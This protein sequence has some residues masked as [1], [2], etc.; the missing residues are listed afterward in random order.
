MDLVIVLAVTLLLGAVAL[1][2]I[3]VHWLRA[4]R[5]TRDDLRRAGDERTVSTCSAPSRLSGGGSVRLYA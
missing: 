2:W 1:V 5:T 4:R 3:I